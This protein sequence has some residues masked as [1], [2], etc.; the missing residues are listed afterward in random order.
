MSESYDGLVSSVTGS[1]DDKLAMN[2]VCAV[3]ASSTSESNASQKVL[4]DWVTRA[5]VLVRFSIKFSAEERLESARG[6]R[7]CMKDE[8]E[9]DGE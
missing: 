5:S 9:D 8:V 3:G 4:Y 2:M 7:T 6:C 1:A